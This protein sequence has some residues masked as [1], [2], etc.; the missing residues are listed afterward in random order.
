MAAAGP[1]AIELA[2]EVADDVLL[3]AGSTPEIVQ[4]AVV[5]LDRG[6]K[7]SGRRAEDLEVIWAVRTSMAS[8]TAEAQRQTRPTV[9]H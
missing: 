6:A 3:L 7:R 1:K 2:G 4:A 8:T 9:I 5:C